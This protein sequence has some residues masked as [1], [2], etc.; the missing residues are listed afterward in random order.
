MKLVDNI[1][2]TCYPLQNRSG[3]YKGQNIVY[4]HDWTKIDWNL[5][6][7]QMGVWKLSGIFMLY[8]NVLIIVFFS[9][10]NSE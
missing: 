8:M 2:V 1:S 3:K 10:T 6:K 9:D 4:Q 5:D 7:L